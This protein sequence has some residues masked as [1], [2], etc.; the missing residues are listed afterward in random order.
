LFDLPEHFFGFLEEPVGKPLSQAARK[1]L[2]SP[3]QRLR[4]PQV[5]DT[6]SL[7]T[8]LTNICTVCPPI[9]LPETCCHGVTCLFAQSP[10]P[11]ITQGFCAIKGRGGLSLQH[12]LLQWLVDMLLVDMFN[13]QAHPVACCRRSAI[14]ADYTCCCTLC[15]SCQ[16]AWTLSMIGQSVCRPSLVMYRMLYHRQQDLNFTP[17]KLL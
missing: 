10:D 2:T 8:E 3:T 16:S 11:G 6:D 4:A 9:S 12:V 13:C 15:N 17:V 5:S 1:L 7:S 14:L